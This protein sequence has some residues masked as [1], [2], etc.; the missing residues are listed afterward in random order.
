MKKAL[1]IPVLSSFLQQ[2]IKGKALNQPE[3][4]SFLDI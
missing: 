2:I 1:V 4:L 3:S